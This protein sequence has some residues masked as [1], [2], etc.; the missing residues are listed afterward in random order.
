MRWKFL[1]VLSS[2]LFILFIS[3]Y[4]AV[5]IL[6]RTDVLPFNRLPYPKFYRNV[7][8]NLKPGIRAT[9]WWN[10]LL[11]YRYSTD[12]N[13]FR[14]NGRSGGPDTVLCIGDSYTFGLGVND[15]ETFPFILGRQLGGAGNI[16]VVNA[17][18]MDVGI[19]EHLE[20]YRTKG[21]ALKPRL[22][23]VQFNI[24]DI[25]IISGKRGDSARKAPIYSP[26]KDD[27][28]ENDITVNAVRSMTK[29]APVAALFGFLNSTPPL[30]PPKPAPASDA[31]ADP[32]LRQVLGSRDKLLDE[33][34]LETMRVPWEKY[35]AKLKELHDAVVADG[36]DFLLLIVPDP[37]Q[38][39]EY[40]NA[41]S[42]ALSGFCRKNGIKFEDMT[43][44]FRTLL[45]D[46]D[47]NPFLE[48]L[49]IHCNATG[50]TLIAQHIVGRIRQASGDGSA[51]LEFT[52]NTQ[53][54]SYTAPVSFELKFTNDGKIVIPDNAIIGSYSVSQENTAT[55]REGGG[56]IKYLTTD[57]AGE[58][59]ARTTIDLSFTRD[60]GQASLVFFPHANPGSTQGDRVD[61]TLRTGD[62][63]ASTSTALARTQDRWRGFDTIAFLEN[64][65]RTPSRSLSVDI[66]FLRDAGLASEDAHGSGPHRRI[67]LYLYPTAP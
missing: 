62:S 55:R 23:I 58:A 13:G 12:S 51:R 47:T 56:G 22:V 25:E 64:R 3:S 33:R 49:D 9:A 2:A 36:A 39:H 15:N 50:N 19:E 41:P 66:A 18:S 29:S 38:V 5:E 30:E 48:P 7:A 61:I 20:F 6:I 21:R 54:P 42:A 63:A 27:S 37:H 44:P 14:T 57:A 32:A 34:N 4:L 11:P 31:D 24:Y 26:V 60:I 1:H 52:D 28:L 35:R 53:S 17:G 46:L 67:E 45:A 40:A 59:F 10:P 8:G 16:S 65:F 43:A